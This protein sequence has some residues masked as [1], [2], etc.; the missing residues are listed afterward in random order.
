LEKYIS[1]IDVA[2]SIGGDNYSFDYGYPEPYIQFDR[3]VLAHKIPLIYWG[4]SIG[5]FT[6]DK[7]FEHRMLSHLP[8]IKTILVRES[9][10]LAYLRSLGIEKNVY[11][12]SDP[13]FI[14]EPVQPDPSHFE[15]RQKKFIGVNF[16]TTVGRLIMPYLRESDPTQS[17]LLENTLNNKA[18]YEQMCEKYVDI[19]VS[20]YELCDG[21]LVFIP[22]AMG[23]VHCDHNFLMRIADFMENKGY[24]RPLVAPPDLTAPE[25]KWII[26][27][28]RCFIG[29]RT[30]STIASFSSGVPT[31]SLSYSQKARGITQD[32]YGKGDFCISAK[33][34]SSEKLQPLVKRL[35]QQEDDL[36]DH[37]AQQAK[38]MTA[39]ALSAGQFLQGLVT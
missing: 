34:V 8:R 27:Q 25:Y 19:A 35:L 16:S 33:E 10:S 26:A 20:L 37:L 21:N 13:A 38:V 15:L 28:S 18:E 31:I 39:R 22:H 23:G 5:P 12:V 9:G 36:R 24:T 14:M 17:S 32:M 29:A 7:K 3:F 30:H 4:L 6:N 11:L 1:D 2:L